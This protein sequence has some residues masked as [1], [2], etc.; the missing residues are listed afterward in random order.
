MSRILSAARPSTST[1]PP[2]DRT[3]HL[4]PNN[5]AAAARR[6]A[7]LYPRVLCSVQ[8]QTRTAAAATKMAVKGGYLCTDITPTPLFTFVA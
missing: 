4:I 7:S 2:T 5:A 3:S 6:N 8:I 1:H